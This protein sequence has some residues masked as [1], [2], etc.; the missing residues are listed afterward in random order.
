M[1]TMGVAALVVLGLIVLIVL[2]VIASYN[3][4]WA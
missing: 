1:R 2:W 4:L 3:R